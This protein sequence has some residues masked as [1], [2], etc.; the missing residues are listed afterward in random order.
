MG[1]AQGGPP[2]ELGLKAQASPWSLPRQNE[3]G[4]SRRGFVLDAGIAQGRQVHTFE[5]ALAAA[6]QD[7]RYGYVHL[8]DKAVAK[9]LLDDIDPATDANIF[10][11][12]GLPGALKSDDST[13]CHEVKGRSAVH[14]ERWA[15]V[16]GEH[17]HGDVIHRVVAP[18]TPPTL[19]RPGTTNWPK[20]VSAEDPRAD[21]LESSSGKLIVDA[22][23]PAIAT[24]QLLLKGSS[25]D[26]P[27]MQRSAANAQWIVD[28][29]VWASAETVQ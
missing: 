14:D 11:S 1:S 22:R 15:R 26:Q 19:V 21:V 25:G 23:F 16:V 17:E 13:F 10:A 12:G 24:K 18:P 6:E 8:V 3:M 7:W 9:V 4:G 27:T 28:V 5:E 29:L 2:L 20:H